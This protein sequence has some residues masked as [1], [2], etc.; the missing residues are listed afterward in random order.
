MWAELLVKGRPVG[1]RDLLIAATAL[2]HGYT[3]VTRD[4]RSF[5]RIPGLGVQRW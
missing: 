5:R 2:A 1:E 3:V 4:E